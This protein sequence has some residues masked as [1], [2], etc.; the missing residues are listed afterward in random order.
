VKAVKDVASITTRLASATAQS[1]IAKIEVFNVQGNELGSISEKRS[2]VGVAID[3]IRK[4]RRRLC[5]DAK[6]LVSYVVRGPL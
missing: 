5:C 6:P 2:R 4:S 3:P 1:T